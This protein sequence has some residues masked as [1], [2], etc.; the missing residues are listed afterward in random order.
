MH[1]SR[2]REILVLFMDKLQRLIKC[3]LTCPQD[4]VQGLLLKVH[5]SHGCLRFLP[6]SLT[7]YAV[8]IIAT[9]LVIY[10]IFILANTFLLF[11]ICLLYIKVLIIFS[12]HIEFIQLSPHK[13][14]F[15]TTVHLFTCM[16]ML[17][18]LVA[19]R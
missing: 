3:S 1:V 15:Y 2:W 4:V 7:S 10:T 18:N 19:R 12:I 13:L 6:F 16:Q 9:L 14:C 5:P 17:S 8:F 11:P